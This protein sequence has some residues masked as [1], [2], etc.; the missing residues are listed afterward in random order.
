M[1][2]RMNP[3]HS[4]QSRFGKLRSSVLQLLSQTSAV[5]GIGK[6]S[7]FGMRGHQEVLH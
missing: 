7:L 4:V 5:G 1:G 6:Q 2:Q 3:M